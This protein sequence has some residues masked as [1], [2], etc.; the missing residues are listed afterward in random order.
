[1]RRRG[2]ASGPSG[3]GVFGLKARKAPTAHA[4]TTDLQ[5]QVD[6]LTRELKEARLGPLSISLCGQEM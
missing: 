4:S 5:E 6:A 1:M 2:T 3:K